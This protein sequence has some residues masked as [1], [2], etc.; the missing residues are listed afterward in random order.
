LS[1]RNAENINEKMR[2]RIIMES[3][4]TSLCVSDDE[5]LIGISFKN[6]T[7]EIRRIE[8]S[9][10]IEDKV[11]VRMTVGNERPVTDLK[12]FEGGCGACLASICGNTLQVESIFN[13][14]EKP[15]YYGEYPD[16]LIQ[17]IWHKE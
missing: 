8:R 4:A 3:E 9:I 2:E 12:I 16:E 17:V 13:Q 14:G 11:L 15:V 6:G 10:L 5:N 7:V 1:F